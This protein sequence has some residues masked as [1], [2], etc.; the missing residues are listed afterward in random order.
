VTTV[1]QSGDLLKD[2][3]NLSSQCSISSKTLYLFDE[4]ILDL[5]TVNYVC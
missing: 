3:N 5:E 4:A 1:T 2:A